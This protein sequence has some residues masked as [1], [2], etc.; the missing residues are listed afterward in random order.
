M[1]LTKSCFHASRS[2]LIYTWLLSYVISYVWVSFASLFSYV[3]VSFAKETYN[4]KEPIGSFH[5]CGSLLPVSFHICGLFC[6]SLFICV[7]LFCQSLFIYI[8]SHVPLTIWKNP[9]KQTY[10]YVF[11]CMPLRT[12]SLP[13]PLP[14]ARPLPLHLLRPHIISSSRNT[15]NLCHS[16]SLSI[17]LEV[18]LP[19]TLSLSLT[20]SLA[21]APAHARDGS[22]R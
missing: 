9:G 21:R 18:I 11:S 15:C 7:G 14:L 1:P 13:R 20:S 16:L 12:S 8:V 5:M 4:L 19:H 3:W 22:R 6:Q 10:I 2:L 17:T